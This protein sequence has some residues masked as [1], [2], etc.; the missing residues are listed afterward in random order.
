MNKSHWLDPDLKASFTPVECGTTIMAF[1]FAD[2]VVLGA[3]SRTTSN[4]MVSN[5]VTD[6]VNR[7]TD[8]VYCCRSGSAADTQQL[9]EEVSI[10]MWRRKMHTGQQT[11]VRDVAAE[12]RDKCYTGRRCLLA[13]IIVGGWDDL[14]G[15]Q[16]Y[17][18]SLGGMMTRE[19]F[20][21]GG[22]GSIYISGMLRDAY[23]PNMQKEDLVLLVQ[24][25]LK[26]AIHHDSF[27]GGVARIAIITK[28]GIERRVYYN[29]STGKAQATGTDGILGSSEGKKSRES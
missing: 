9:A 17:N 26:Q 14:H 12:F 13:G 5:R 23:R 7:I 15:A 18:I 2:G 24:S 3:D 25:A 16:V 29:T 22:T 4:C 10:L 8:N 11:L 21:Y 20:S 19:N 27:S 6:K 1:E 28:E